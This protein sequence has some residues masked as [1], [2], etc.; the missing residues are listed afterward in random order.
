[1]KSK[2]ISLGCLVIYFI[3]MVSFV[4]IR[5]CNHYGLFYFL[6][7]YGGYFISIFTQLGLLF[8]VSIVLYK[9]FTKASFKSTFKAFNFKKISSKTILISIAI[10]LVVFCLNIYVANFFNSIIGFF[11]YKF[12]HSTS[13][14]RPEWWMFLLNLFCTA[15]LPAI[16]EETLHRGML[17]RGVSKL[18]IKKSIFFTGL[19]FG[20]MHLNIEQFFYATIIGWFLGYLLIASNSIYP[21]IIVHFINNA[22][23]VFLSFARANKWPI[24]NVFSHLNQFLFKNQFLGFVM[25]F[26]FLILLVVLLV[27]LTKMIMKESFEYNVGAQQKKLTSMVIRESYFTQIESIKNNVESQSLYSSKDNVIYINAND[28]LNFVG[29]S[30]DDIRLNPKKKGSLDAKSKVFLYGSLALSAIITIMT[31]IW[32]LF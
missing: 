21:C 13:N 29:K 22:I 20:L 26:L 5:V 9:T 32:G 7:E 27:E 18:G 11:G 15:V 23:S 31:F 30:I 12:S 1:M 16:A 28:L 2:N 8:F 19:L 14:A 6:G 25:V 10:G 24:G 3:I 4:A 17:M